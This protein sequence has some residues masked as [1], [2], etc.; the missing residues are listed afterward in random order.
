MP[1]TAHDDEGNIVFLTEINSL[2]PI[3]YLEQARQIAYDYFIEAEK[4]HATLDQM[5]TKFV[6]TIGATEATHCWCPRIGYTH[7]LKMQLDRMASYNLEWIGTRS[8][9]IDDDHQ[10]LLN[11]FV[12][13]T[14]EANMILTTLN[15]EEII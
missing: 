13:I 1:Y 14:T 3:Q 4:T 2:C 11:K 15:L 7:Q 12:C 9:T 8:Y 10:E 5:F 6:K